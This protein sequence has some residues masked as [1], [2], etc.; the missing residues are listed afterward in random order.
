M[1]TTPT[2]EG[3]LTGRSL[4]ASP[5][6]ALVIGVSAA[7]SMVAAPVLSVFGAR[8]GVAVGMLPFALVGAVVLRRQPGNAVG[9]LLL[10]LT[11][12]IVAS[13]DAAQYDVLRYRLGYR[14]LPFGRVAVFFGTPGAWMWLVVFLPLTIALFPDGR[15]TRGWRRM[16]WG[17][18]AL[19]AVF[20][21]T[22]WWQ[23]AGGLGARHLQ[24]N[25]QGQLVSGM[26]GSLGG[27][28]ATVGI[29]A[30]Y[31]GFCVAW[32]LRLVLRYRRST[33]DFRQQLKW[34]GVGG[35]LAVTGLALVTSL[36]SASSIVLRLIGSV[37]LVVSLL[38]LPISLAVAILKYRLY[39]IDRLISRTLSYAIVT[40]LLV[41]TF[42]GLVALTTDVLPFSS[43]V[44]VAASTLV[45]AA[46]FN[47]L[48]LRV[49]RIVDRR[50]NRA[51]Y[52]AEA[53]VA[54][55]AAHL[56]EAVDFEAVRNELLLTVNGA[57]QPAHAS[58]W[59]RATM[60]S[61]SA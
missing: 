20:V 54:A 23:T 40:G 26:G 8:A 56:R 30:A 53:T 35:A 24:V 45:A 47:P 18:L 13:D 50:F 3:G 22:T 6:A 36:N 27:S 28:V 39:E 4:L 14:H 12:A 44:G 19:C 34:L 41:A 38:A 33:G 11:F 16:L 7:L 61:S 25:S 37:G 10:L 21:A 42:V 29:V 43:P 15:L 31:L 55:F 49:Q 5:L 51:R 59:I 46:L 58:L 52:D 48:R 17:Y 60:T 1:N 32:T 9:P 57:V 2:A